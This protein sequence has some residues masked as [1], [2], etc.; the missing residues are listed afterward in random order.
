VLSSSISFF[1]IVDV[2]LPHLWC[3]SIDPLLILLLLVDVL[4]VL[5][6]AYHW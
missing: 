4:G 2:C 3:L 5:T 1:Q 6:F